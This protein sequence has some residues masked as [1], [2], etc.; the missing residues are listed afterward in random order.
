M[1]GVAEWKKK[2]TGDDEI[3]FEERGRKSASE[4]AN[5]C[6]CVFEMIGVVKDDEVLFLFEVVANESNARSNGIGQG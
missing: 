4:C 5:V 2:G 6:M 1:C 3:E